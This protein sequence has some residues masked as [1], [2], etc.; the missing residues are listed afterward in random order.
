M[1]GKI[2]LIRHLYGNNTY[3]RNHE[4]IIRTEYVHNSH[5]ENPPQSNETPHFENSSLDIYRILWY[6]KIVI[7]SMHTFLLGGVGRPA[8]VRRDPPVHVV[9]FVR[10]VVTTIGDYY[11]LLR[12]RSALCLYGFLANGFAT[13]RHIGKRRKALHAVSSLFCIPKP[14]VRRVV[15]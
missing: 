3:Y 1:A 11:A 13:A 6:I 9:R 2:R 10:Y 7:D 12:S 4:P 15:R 8:Y 5:Y 14:R